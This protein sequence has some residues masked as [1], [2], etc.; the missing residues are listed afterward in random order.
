[1][2]NLLPLRH[3]VVALTLA[4]ASNG[5]ADEAPRPWPSPSESKCD[6]RAADLYGQPPTRVTGKIPAPK[7]T[8]DAKPKY[9][10]RDPF[11]RG[12]GLWMAEALID[13]EGH[14]REVWILRDLKFD[15]PWA[16]YSAAISDALLQWRY[17]PT[18]VDGTPVAVCMVVTTNVHWR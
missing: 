4:F 10:S 3:V 6:L 18:V 9:P 17:T 16:E 14:V 15:P 5:G 8:H 2:A 11:G 7:K 12:S 1:M 13:P